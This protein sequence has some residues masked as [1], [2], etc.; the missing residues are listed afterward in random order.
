LPGAAAGA[1]RTLL[2]AGSWGSMG[3][4]VMAQGFL[5][6]RTSASSR[7][8]LLHAF[9]DLGLF[10]PLLGAALVFLVLRDHAAQRAFARMRLLPG[11]AHLG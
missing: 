2:A 10:A 9:V 3:A 8:P 6:W 11:V 7:P 5:C 4:G 1:L